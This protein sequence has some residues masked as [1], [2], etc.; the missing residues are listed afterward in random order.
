MISNIRNNSNINDKNSLIR[1]ILDK[2]IIN[3]IMD[4][5]SMDDDL[6]EEL[7]ND[8]FKHSLKCKTLQKLINNEGF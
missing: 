4:D 2:L 7:I 8:T 5:E 6:K 1:D 3:D